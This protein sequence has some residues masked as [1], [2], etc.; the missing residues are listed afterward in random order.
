MNRI[1]LLASISLVTNLALANKPIGP[2]PATPMQESACPAAMR[3]H[4]TKI[5]FNS[6]GSFA[7][8]AVVKMDTSSTQVVVT[9]LDLPKVGW[10]I[11]GPS[12]SK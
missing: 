4:V 7:H 10:F 11:C 9:S 2:A 12:A 6:D 1:V 8:T 3:A 5:N